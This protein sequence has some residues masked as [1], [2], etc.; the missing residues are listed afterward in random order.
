MDDV[1]IEFFEVSK[2][3]KYSWSWKI[4]SKSGYFRCNSFNIN[5]DNIG[6]LTIKPNSEILLHSNIYFNYKRK[7]YINCDIKTNNID[8]TEIVFFKELNKL[9]EKIIC[10]F[11]DRYRKNLNKDILKVVYPLENNTLTTYLAKT[12]KNILLTEF[13]YMNS[14]KKENNISNI[15]HVPN[16]YLYPELIIKSI[17]LVKKTLYIDIVIIKSIV[18][19]SMFTKWYDE[20]NNKQ[21]HIMKCPTEIILKILKYVLNYQ[22]DIEAFAFS[23]KRFFSIFINNYN[24]LHERWEYSSIIDKNPFSIEWKHQ[25]LKCIYEL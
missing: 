17:N 6:N 13:T 19:K 1:K 11:F 4:R 8:Y 12:D 20:N 21:I 14:C 16:I 22:N 10:S 7:G 2:K 3:D 9:L 24:L 23:C 25:R 18:Y 15:I 5:V